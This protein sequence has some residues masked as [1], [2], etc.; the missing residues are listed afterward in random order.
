M[1]LVLGECEKTMSLVG[2]DSLGK[3]VSKYNERA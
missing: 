2:D 3:G 1:T